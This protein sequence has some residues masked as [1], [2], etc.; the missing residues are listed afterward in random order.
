MRVPPYYRRPGWQRFFAG[1]IIGIL[2]GWVFF[3]LQYGPIHDEL[4][5][6]RSKQQAEV[7]QLKERIDDL[8]RKQN[9]QNEEN[10]KKLTIQ[11]IEISFTNARSL[12]LNQLTLYEL[13]Q[14][15]IEEL[16]FLEQRDIETVANM[17][18]LMISTL[19]NKV[20]SINDSRYQLD[21]EE[22][23]LFTTLHIYAKIVPASS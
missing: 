3:L 10:Q 19:E 2:I 11:E 5:L 17:K 15:A 23:Y 6:E 7:A 1:L 16:H 22:V 18:D 20:F 9:E 12:R 14:Q 4:I 21:V 13:H 8:V